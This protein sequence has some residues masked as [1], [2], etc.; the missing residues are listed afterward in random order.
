[1]DQRK[2]KYKLNNLF[3]IKYLTNCPG[4]SS[5]FGMGLRISS[6]SL[7]PSSSSSSPPVAAAEASDL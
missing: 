4:F 5:V 3:F 7:K 2:I 1:M 6:I